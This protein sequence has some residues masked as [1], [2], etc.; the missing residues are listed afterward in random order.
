M[1]IILILDYTLY[2]KDM[3][4][5][6]NE[7]AYHNHKKIFEKEKKKQNYDTATLG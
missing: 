4:G 1:I 7:E 5:K 3:H 6:R 2:V